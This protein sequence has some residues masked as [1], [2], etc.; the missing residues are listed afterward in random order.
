LCA[1]L[2]AATG[3]PWGTV[4]A[5]TPSTAGPHVARPPTGSA[6]GYAKA[7]RLWLLLRIPVPAQL[8]SLADV[9]ALPRNRGRRTRTHASWSCH[10][11]GSGPWGGCWL[12]WLR[13][14]STSASQTCGRTHTP[15]RLSGRASWCP[16]RRR[17]SSRSSPS[18]SSLARCARPARSVVRLTCR[19]GGTGPSQNHGGPRR[20]RPGPPPLV[21]RPG[22]PAGHPAAA[23]RAPVGQLV[24]GQRHPRRYESRFPGHSGPDHRPD[25]R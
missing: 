10:P 1:A 17:T 9:V 3:S 5:V 13:R 2:G 18:P 6:S 14:P 7:P 21:T 16:S 19:K 24:P 25:A 20:E 15:G 12:P 4:T 11:T 23:R 22:R 8:D